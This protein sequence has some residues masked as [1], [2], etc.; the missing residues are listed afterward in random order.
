MIEEHIQDGDYVVVERGEQARNGQTVVA[1]VGES[2]ATLKKFYKRGSR[3]TLEPANR[4]LR[5]IQVH[6]SDVSIRGVVRGLLR[7]Y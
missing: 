2:D 4:A 7:R 3:V 5:P 6:A 1:V